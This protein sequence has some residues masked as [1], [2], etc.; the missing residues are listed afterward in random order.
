V[1]ETGRKLLE[2]LEDMG[3]IV[4]VFL[5]EGKLPTKQFLLPFFAGFIFWWEKFLLT[6]QISV[7]S[8]N[9]CCLNLRPA[10]QRVI[11]TLLCQHSKL[12]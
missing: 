6:K 5:D 7:V 11:I 12:G 1:S 9:T 2:T 8:R 4:F 3:K 10:D